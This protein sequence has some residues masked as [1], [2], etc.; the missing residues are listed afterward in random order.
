MSIEYRKTIEK[1]YESSVTN[2]LHDAPSFVSSFYDHMHHGKR[3][4]TTQFFYIR[5][6]LDFLLY[7]KSVLPDLESVS[8]DKFPLETLSKLTIQD[9]NEYREFLFSERKLSNSSAKK[10]LAALSAFYKFLCSEDYLQTNPMMN[11][12]YPVINKHR[13]I[14]L[15]AG[16]SNKLLAGILKNDKY[17]ATSE[18]GEFVGEI[19][20]KVKIKRERLVL[21]NYAICYLFLGAGLRVSELVGLDLDDINFRQNSVNVILKGG[22]ETQVYFGDEVAEALKLYLNGIELSPSLSEKYSDDYELLDWCDDHVLD[23][24]LEKSIEDA[25]PEAD[26]NKINDIKSLVSH[27]RRQGRSSFKPERNC[28]AVFLSSRGKRIT[29]RMVELMIKEMVKT[30]LPEY[31]DKDL[32]SPHKLR[33]TCA[34]RIL[35][36]TGNIELASTQLNHKGVAVTAAFYAELQKEKRKDQIKSLDVTEW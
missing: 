28:N 18:Y 20:D 24:E 2:L 3:E 31:D 29:V 4:I 12:E 26:S 14:K 23:N 16:L 9:I 35:S 17:L 15:D 13:I 25:F 30:Y 10:K 8:L 1:K 34:T 27:Y 5:D 36:Q 33:A 32:F 6:V 22:D 21:R 11:F 7:I 19:P